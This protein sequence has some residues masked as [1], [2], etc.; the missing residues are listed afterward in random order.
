LRVTLNFN[1]DI[2]NPYDLG[3]VP[4]EASSVLELIGSLNPIEVHT[5][6]IHAGTKDVTRL[7]T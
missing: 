1:L 4:R 5:L 7:E 3:A 2:E 6:P